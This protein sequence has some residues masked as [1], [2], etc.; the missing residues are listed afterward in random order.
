[1]DGWI[2]VQLHLV[3]WRNTGFQ[4][5]YSYGSP[6]H[7][8][9]SL[10]FSSLRYSSSDSAEQYCCN[11]R[12]AKIL[13]LRYIFRAVSCKVFI[14][15]HDLYEVTSNDTFA[16]QVFYEHPYYDPKEI[17]NDVALVE[18]PREIDFSGKKCLAFHFKIAKIFY[19]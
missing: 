13:T 8:R 7:P 2:V 9:V 10:I 4:K 11:V 17:K 6:L 3:L 18:L 12:Y 1:M 5:T 19:A 16:S 14:G 15:T